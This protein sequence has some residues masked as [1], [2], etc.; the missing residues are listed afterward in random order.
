MKTRIIVDSTA[1]LM[2]DYKKRVNIVPL[3]NGGQRNRHP[4]RSRRRGRGILQKVN[5][6]KGVAQRKFFRHA[7]ALW[8]NREPHCPPENKY[9]SR[10]CAPAL[11]RKIF[12]SN[13]NLST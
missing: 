5:T 1:D 4:R 11:W 8:V 12:C 6:P 3:Y 9:V 13:L 2:P 10:H 7:L